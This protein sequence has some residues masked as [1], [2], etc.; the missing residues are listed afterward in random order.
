M[1]IFWKTSEVAKEEAR[2]ADLKALFNAGKL[3]VSEYIT[4]INQL[5]G[6]SESSGPNALSIIQLVLILALVGTGIYVLRFIRK[7]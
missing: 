4:A 7:A 2:L 1:A 5:K 6:V 3:S